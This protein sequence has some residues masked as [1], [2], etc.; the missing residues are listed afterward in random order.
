MLPKRPWATLLRILLI[1]GLM[2]I[3]FRQTREIDFKESE[4]LT[5]EAF[6]DIY[7]PGCDEHLVLHNIRKSNCY[8]NELDLV[9]VE[10]E[11]I[12]GHIIC[13]RAKVIDS[14]NHEYIVL[15]VGPFSIEKNH[16]GK[17][18]GYKLMEYCIVKAKELGYAGMI[19][20]G[21]PNYYHRF[22]FRNAVEYGIRTKEGLN[23]EPFMVKE[24]QKEGLR[25][26]QGAFYEDKSYTI[27]MDE[28]IEFE[29]QFPYK[30]KHITSTQLKS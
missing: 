1:Y 24:L 28:L 6:W 25:K 2:E 13:T 10:C 7:K 16:Q 21:N 29:E 9:A 27:D 26:I 11:K 3:T 20:F 8:I 4:N 5:R 30:E 15:C 18:Y 23:F 17:G 14:K 22:G 12:I 19:L